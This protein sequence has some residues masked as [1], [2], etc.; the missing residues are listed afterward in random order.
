MVDGGINDTNIVNVFKAGANK[1]VVGS[2]ITKDVNNCLEKIEHLQS[3][4]N[5]K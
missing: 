5:L 3:L 1:V 2:Y 4:I